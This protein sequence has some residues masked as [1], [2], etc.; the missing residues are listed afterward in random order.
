MMQN[1]LFLRPELLLLFLPLVALSWF[2]YKRSS[3]EKN[4]SQ[5]IEP[6]LLK[7]L[8]IRPKVKQSLF[9]PF[10]LLSL[11]L[12][13]M[14]IAL[15]GPSWSL[16]NETQ[17]S[18]KTKIA[19]VIK[20]TKS[21]ESKDLRPSRLKRSVFKLKDLFALQSDMES[22]LIAY[23]ASAHL[24]MPMSRDSEIIFNFADALSSTIMPQE[25]D[26]LHKALVLAD[27][28]LKEKSSSIV[29]FCDGISSEEIQKLQKEPELKNRN[30]IFYAIGSKELVDTRSIQKAA[31]ALSAKFV[32]YAADGSDM[33][34][35][36][37]KIIANFE[38]SKRLD[39]T[40]RVDN[41]YVLLPFIFLTLLFF[42]QKGVAAQ[43]WRVR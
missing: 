43:V 39:K 34:D 2:L 13:L 35:L 6:H 15:S 31:D 30:I 1:F 16:K 27:K 36:E 17:K 5:V 42:F 3:D 23:S 9:N 32:E 7:H 14:V 11:S 37:S 18:N 8:L 19:T 26:A 22:L 24:V 38:S 25:G 28:Q 4:L 21:M 29:V 10:W 12:S 40:N 41:G 20:V 33:V